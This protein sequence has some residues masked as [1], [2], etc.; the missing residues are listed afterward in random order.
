MVGAGEYRYRP[1]GIEGGGDGNIGKYRYRCRGGDGGEKGRGGE[2]C[3]RVWD[4]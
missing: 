2:R 1:G 4:G 3:N